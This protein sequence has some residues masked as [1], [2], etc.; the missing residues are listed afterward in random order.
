[1]ADCGIPPDSSL[2]GFNYD[3]TRDYLWAMSANHRNARTNR[4]LSPLQTGGHQRADSDFQDHD[5]ML[6]WQFQQLQ[7]HLHYSI[8]QHD[9]T[10]TTM[11]LSS[12]PVDLTGQP[13]LDTTSLLDGSSYMPLSAR[14]GIS[15]LAPYADF[16][17]NILNLQGLPP[18][19]AYQ[20]QQQNGLDSSS[21]TD[22]YLEVRSLNSSSSDNGWS[23]VEHP[24][25]QF[26]GLPD[27]G[28]F[29]DPNQTLHDQSVSDS[30]YASSSSLGSSSGFVEVFHR[31]LV[32][33][34]T[35]SSSE[36]GANV[37]PPFTSVPR[38][39]SYD[40]SDS[41]SPTAVASPVSTSRP[42]PIPE[43]KD[44]SPSAASHSSTSSSSASPTK[45]TVS[46][47][48]DGM[49]VRKQS[50]GG[51]AEERRVGKRKGPLNP[52]Q[53]KQASEIRKL[54]ACLRCRFLKKTVWRISMF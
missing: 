38:R 29:I 46:S 27:P 20:Q 31:P 8:Q 23:F 17:T 35:A 37:P 10:Y 51:K 6:D 3:S 30:S 13:Q 9:P 32:P 4:G 7:H 12:S 41:L 52:N 28:I 48:T 36:M 45:I 53:R 5:L 33:S 24:H 21:P 18:P 39:I 26:S 54:R 15:P 14:V 50:G 49:R 11:P 34:P 19:A 44:A 1:M 43:R 25:M 47:K 22:S 40:S 2:A 16:Q 42:V